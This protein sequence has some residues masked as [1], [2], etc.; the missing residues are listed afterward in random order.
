MTSITHQSRA[1][2]LAGR[3][4]KLRRFMHI[5]WDWNGTLFDDLDIVVAAVNATI[6]PLG[7][8]PISHDDYRAHYVRPVRLFYERL[9]DRAVSRE[10][11]HR[12]DDAFHHDYNEAVHHVGLA[13][14]AL[15]ALDLVERAGAT[16][17]LL[18]MYP[19][20]ELLPLATRHGVADSMVLIEGRRGTA[21]ASKRDS[22][23]RH[24]DA[25]L[26]HPHTT[27]ELEEFVVIG[28]AL[29]DATAA[30]ASGLRCILYDNG[31]HPFDHLVATGHPVTQS[32]MTAL[33]LAGLQA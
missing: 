11:W 21:G 14:D 15:D 29:D 25:I 32:L 23:V 16:Q 18:S 31:S 26:G 1:T 3:S 6:E 8:G 7:A 27:A 17:S 10:E 30:D 24:V 33:D 13:V 19:H 4:R 22:M 20:D 5:I 28:D 12:F 2:A 9:L